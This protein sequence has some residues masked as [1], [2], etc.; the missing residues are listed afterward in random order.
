MTDKVT[1]DTTKLFVG[2]AN[3]CQID[4]RV[5]GDK[6][7][8]TPLEA[9]FAEVFGAIWDPSNKRDLQIIEKEDG[10]LYATWYP[11]RPPLA[12]L[13]PIFASHLHLTFLV[14]CWEIVI[15]FRGKI[16]WEN[17]EQKAFAFGEYGPNG[18]DLYDIVAP[19]P[20]VFAPYI[21]PEP[22]P[23]FKTV[24]EYFVAGESGE[25][26]PHDDKSGEGHL[27]TNQHEDREETR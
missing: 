17:G 6:D 7:K 11:W 14:E 9:Q 23:R 16:V 22:P 8:L 2:M 12:E 3:R 1:S 26:G 21:G 13:E 10:R 15:G 25:K 24:E 19:L 18:D 5:I 20:D 4:I 27:C